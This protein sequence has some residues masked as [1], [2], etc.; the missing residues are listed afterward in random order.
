M[1]LED[2]IDI[3]MD[4]AKAQDY[5]NSLSQWIDLAH[6]SVEMNDTEPMVKIYN[7]Y[8]NLDEAKNLLYNLNARY[9]RQEV[10]QKEEEVYEDIDSVRWKPGVIMD[11]VNSVIMS[12]EE[13]IRS[14]NDGNNGT[15]NY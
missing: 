6:L 10:Y 9:N 11:Q 3:V 14:E 5:V 8:F 4:I 13:N 7:L 2:K 1:Y 12:D 15:T